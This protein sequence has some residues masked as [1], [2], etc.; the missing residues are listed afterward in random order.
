MNSLRR[1]GILGRVDP[2]LIALLLL[3]IFALSPLM[4]PG[5]FWG[6]HDARHSVYFLFEF[7]Q[8][9][10]DGALY[11]RWAPDFTFGYGYPFFNIYAPLPFYV[12]EAFH[13]LGFGFV[14]AVKI[15][16]GL[17]ILLSGLGMYG[18]LRRLFGRQ[19]ALLGALT[20]VYVPYHLFDL[21]VRA[22]LS[23][24]VALAFLPLVLWG[25]HEAMM[26]PSIKT[27]VAAGLAY[28]GLMFSSNL[29]ALM[30]TPILAIYVF[31]LIV[32]QMRRAQ[33]F[34]ALSR[35]SLMPLIGNFAHYAIP[36]LLAIAI[37]LGISA[38]FWMP[39]ILENSVR[40]RR[41]VAGRRLRLSRRFRL[42]APTL[43]ALLGLWHQR[44]R[45]R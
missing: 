22:A 2:Y 39:A 8:A 41:S 18:F 1:R 36:P 43:L 14:P 42:P 10:Q 5:Y 26:R 28:A 33:S 16:F 27:I 3:M 34:G 29:I 31:V 15:V 12:G 19:A 21:Y 45:P 13:L 6:A 11:P 37:G 4:Q 24:S 23:E 32:A 44:P 38:I 30:F 17:S 9:I 35:E 20:Y 40:S 7:D 25:F